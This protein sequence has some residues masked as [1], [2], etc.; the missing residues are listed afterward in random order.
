MCQGGSHGKVREIRCAG[1][2]VGELASPAGSIPL[3]LWL[4]DIYF[5]GIGLGKH[6]LNVSLEPA[7]ENKARTRV[8]H[9]IACQFP[10]MPGYHILG[11]W[12][13]TPTKTVRGCPWD[14]PLMTLHCGLMIRALVLVSVTEPRLG[15]WGRTEPGLRTP[16][17]FL[18]H[19]K[20]FET[21]QLKKDSCR[22]CWDSW[23]A[24]WRRRITVTTSLRPSGAAWRDPHVK[25]S[26]GV[27]P[28]ASRSWRWA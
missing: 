21:L 23:G 10:Q 6:F 27:R 7:S 3:F 8:S 12:V 13:L 26:V 24:D 4:K 15:S 22:V 16:C 1:N 2:E 18:L 25:D 17:G 20:R 28:W 5:L 19:E 11:Q 9:L 14:S